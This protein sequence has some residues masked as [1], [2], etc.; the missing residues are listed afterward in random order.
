MRSRTSLI[1]CLMTLVAAPA[2]GSAYKSFYK[3]TNDDLAPAPVAP[4]EVK[5][6]K[7]RD[8]LTSG[9]TELGIFRGKAPTVK[10]AMDMA[11]RECGR[12]GANY[13]ILNVEPFQSEGGWKIDGI[14]AAKT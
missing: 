2:C 14:C 1:V 9:W 13:Y 7:S 8:D 10:E 3:K 4:A 6:V 11:K 12:A 5:V